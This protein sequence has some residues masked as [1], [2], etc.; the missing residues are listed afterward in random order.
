MEAN[1]EIL[2]MLELAGKDFKGAVLTVFNE[3]KM[4]ILDEKKILA[5]KKN[6]KRKESTENSRTEKQ[7]I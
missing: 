6:I 7:C 3:V 1:S 4:L 2:Q 5:E